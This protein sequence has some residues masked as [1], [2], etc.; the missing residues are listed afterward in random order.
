MKRAPSMWY[1]AKGGKRC[2][3]T[4]YYKG[5]ELMVQEMKICK[6]DNKLFKREI[7]HKNSRAHFPHLQ[8]EV[9]VT[10]AFKEE[11]EEEQQQQQ[12]LE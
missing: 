2:S 1:E 7:L 4:I 10:V 11:K 3:L 12:Q 8:N 9:R 6:C 5:M